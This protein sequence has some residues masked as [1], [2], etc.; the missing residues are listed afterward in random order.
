MMRERK[1]MPDG[2]KLLRQ[3]L[4]N[5]EVL[6]IQKVSTDA[7]PQQDPSQDPKQAP[8]R[9]PNLDRPSPKKDPKPRTGPS[10]M[11]NK[12][13][14]P[15]NSNPSYMRD[16]TTNSNTKDCCNPMTMRD[17]RN[18]STDWPQSHTH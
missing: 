6:K 18:C 1:L 10:P 17:P 9:V 4:H 5:Y 12:D 15:R 14:R 7:K 11:T 13:P 3:N 2:E 8:I 16:H